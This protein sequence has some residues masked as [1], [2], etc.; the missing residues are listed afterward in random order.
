MGPIVQSSRRPR[1]TE[2]ASSHLTQIGALVGGGG[3][4]HHVVQECVGEQVVDH[5][6]R[7]RIRPV[8]A[9]SL[10]VGDGAQ[11]IRIEEEGLRHLHHAIRRG[12]RRAHGWT[13][14]LRHGV[15]EPGIPGHGRGLV[16][17]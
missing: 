3:L 11:Q 2:L 13:G 8:I 7:K 9:L 4:S 1:L 10:A 16:N 5:Q 17:S 14:G 6:V 15:I 12:G